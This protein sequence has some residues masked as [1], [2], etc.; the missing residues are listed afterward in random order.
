MVCPPGPYVPVVPFN[1]SWS[2]A[3]PRLNV[4]SGIE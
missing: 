4:A 1:S 2:S 3:V